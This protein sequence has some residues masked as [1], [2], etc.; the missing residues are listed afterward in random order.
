MN[1]GNIEKV[2]LATFDTLSYTVD[3]IM[4]DPTMENQLH[5]ETCI[6]G[7]IHAVNSIEGGNVNDINTEFNKIGG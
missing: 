1:T 4:A 3:T 2:Q 7:D 5:P 6:L